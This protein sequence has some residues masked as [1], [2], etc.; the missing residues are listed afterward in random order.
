MAVEIDGP[1]TPGAPTNIKV[2]GQVAPSGDAPLDGLWQ[3]VLLA[4]LSGGTRTPVSDADPLPVTGTFTPADAPVARNTRGT[5]SGV[6]SGG[7]A[8]VVSF[9]ADASWRCRGLI[10]F[11]ESDAT[12]RITYDDV[13]A[14]GLRT[15]IAD[16][17]A[18]LVLPNADDA[19]ASTAVK[20]VVT[21]R[22]PDAANFEAT[23]L[24]E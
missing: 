8:T 20:V 1:A 14:Y 3:L 7:T 6:A 10:G 12:W 22:G 17:T 15:N 4:F 24:G 18:R 13:P 11:G 21:N 5:A 23:L 2:A 9:V 16:P 19:A